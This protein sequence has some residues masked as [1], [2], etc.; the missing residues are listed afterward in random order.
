MKTQD[1]TVW[2]LGGT[3]TLSHHGQ[4]NGATAGDFVVARET[5]SNS[6]PRRHVHH[7]RRFKAAAVGSTWARWT[8]PRT[9]GAGD[10]GRI[11][12]GVL[13]GNGI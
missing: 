1:F 6:L 11:G 9:T 7:H 4:L 12:Q 8:W 5:C 3:G 2:H 13:L 10:S